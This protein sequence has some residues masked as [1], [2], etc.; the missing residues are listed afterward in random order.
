VSSD[1]AK[2]RIVIVRL[3]RNSDEGRE[4]FGRVNESVNI[5]GC[6][7]WEWSMPPDGRAKGRPNIEKNPVSLEVGASKTS[8]WS[9]RRL[10]QCRVLLCC[11][12]TERKGPSV[13][14]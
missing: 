4:L 14:A 3:V 12:M 8:C 1:Q 11:S 7:H 5:S 6:S 13:V 2:D 10:P 9:H